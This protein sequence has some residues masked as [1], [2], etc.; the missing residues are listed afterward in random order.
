M[1]ALTNW[2]AVAIDVSPARWDVPHVAVKIQ[3]LGIGELGIR[4][5]GSLGSPVWRN[6]PAQAV[7][8]VASAEV[9]EAGFCIAFFAGEFVM[10]GVVGD[11]LKFSAPGV[12]IGFGFH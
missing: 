3:A 7:R 12:I 8:V 2:P 4:N 10:V 9:V 1:S 6:E 5:R 11:E